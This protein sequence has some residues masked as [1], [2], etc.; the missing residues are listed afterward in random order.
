LRL[1]FRHLRLQCLKAGAGASEH[2]H[3]AVEFFPANQIQL[4]EPALQQGLELGFEFA[5]R[6][7]GFAGEEAG[8][9]AAQGVEEGFGGEHDEIP[10]S[11]AASVARRFCMARRVRL[12]TLFAHRT[13]HERTVV[14]RC[15]RA[16]ATLE[17]ESTAEVP[18]IAP[19][20]EM[21]SFLLSGM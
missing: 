14:V 7:R 19:I 12:C 9:V 4:A 6:N 13:V 10:E 11:D 15:Q 18:K 5:A 20:H 8:G 1:H 2:N 17:H 16:V 3:L 21:A